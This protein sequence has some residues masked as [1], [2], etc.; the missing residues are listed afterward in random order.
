M[1]R[2]NM[3]SCLFSLSLVLHVRLIYFLTYSGQVL[4]FIWNS[5]FIFSTSRFHSSHTRVCGARTVFAKMRRRF[6]SKLGG[7]NATSVLTNP[8]S[9][10]R[11]KGTDIN[12]CS[13]PDPGYVAC[14]VKHCCIGISLQCHCVWR[15]WDRMKQ[16]DQLRLWFV[17]IYGLLLKSK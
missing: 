2:P 11:I 8:H 5:S 10:I 17:C 12:N 7:E 14:F 16:A 6:W 1:A 3:F 4:D 15:L 9:S 13:L